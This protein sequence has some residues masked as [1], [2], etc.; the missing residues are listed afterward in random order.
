MDGWLSFLLG[1]TGGARSRVEVENVIG[2]Q[3]DRGMG[4]GGDP[5]ARPGKKEG[6]GPV[7]DLDECRV[8]ADKS[9][10]GVAASQGRD[11]SDCPNAGGG[12]AH[13]AAKAPCGA[14]ESG[15]KVRVARFGRV[16]GASLAPRCKVE[17][18]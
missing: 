13:V 14:R 17:Q 16:L 8:G 5:G 2:G 11:G 7:I 15:S 6:R 10:K 18:C 9:A 1:G 4:S 3:G 12:P